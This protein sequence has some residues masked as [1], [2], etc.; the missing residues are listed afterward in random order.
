[1]IMLYLQQL[2]GETTEGEDSGVAKV[3]AV[4]DGDI[5]H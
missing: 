3:I 5:D 1:M 2:Q 4:N